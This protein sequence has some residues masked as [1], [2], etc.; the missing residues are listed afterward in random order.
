MN[1]FAQMDNGIQD[2][3]ITLIQQVDDEKFLRQ[4]ELFWHIN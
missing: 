4:R 2:W 1:T 3:I